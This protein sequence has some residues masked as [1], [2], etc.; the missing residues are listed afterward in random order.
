MNFLKKITDYPLRFLIPF[1]NLLG[2]FFSLF[3]FSIL[4]TKIIYKIYQNN[5][6]NQVGIYKNSLAKV[7]NKKQVFDKEKEIFEELSFLHSSF[8]TK[9]IFVINSLTN[10]ILYSTEIFYLYKDIKFLEFT[11]YNFI[12]D[13]FDP[14]HKHPYQTQLASLQED[15]FHI[16]N[17]YI[18]IFDYPQL[19]WKIVLIHEKNFIDFFL[20]QNI[21]L[22]LL[23]I[24]IHILFPFLFVNFIYNHYY[25]KRFQNILSF[26]EEIKNKNFNVRIPIEGKDEISYISSFL[27]NL[28][29]NIEK[30]IFYDSLTK[31]YNR[32]GFEFLGNQILKKVKSCVIF[33]MDLDGF[34]NVNESFGHDIG[35]IALKIISNRLNS[36]CENNPLGVKILLGR[37]GG[38]EFALLF[39][40]KL[41]YRNYLDIQI[42][43]TKIIEEVSQ[44]ITI[45]EIDINLGISIGIAIYPKDGKSLNE[46]LT[47]SDLAMYHSKNTTKN[48]YHFFSESIK[49]TYEQKNL[50]RNILVSIIKNKIIEKHFYLVYQPIYSLKENKITHIEALIR[51]RHDEIYAEPS[52]FI[53]LLEE[54]NFIEEIGNYVIEKSLNDYLEIK[55]FWDYK[56]SINL[57]LMQ[58]KSNQFFNSLKKTL[59]YLS[60]EPEKIIFEITESVFIKDPDSIIKAINSLVDF[61]ISF[62]LDDF[63]TGYSSL[64]YLKSFPIQYIKI[65]KSF[66]LNIINDEKSYIL[67]RSLFDLSKTINCKVIAEGV[68]DISTFNILKE[69]NCDY[70]QGYLISKPLEKKELITFLTKYSDKII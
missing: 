47:N 13:F 30:L 8:D 52:F 37:I 21:Y 19:N 35:D 18:Y 5:F 58:L 3:I 70:V 28:V 15:L 14:N 27:N 6:I 63:G 20:K 48:T 4:F 33:F 29:E 56:I 65:D 45:N 68:Q 7:I 32:F 17:H 1:F 34:K 57:S 60:I 41:D 38:D 59:T 22:I 44:K 49:K 66:L 12:L 46:L 31:V 43:A 50:L 51:F 54:L 25:K 40:T 39:S 11:S 69:L 24:F 10:Q 23:M 16:K 61:G 64:H 26:S 53:P 55:N 9:A 36:L 67:L 62:A 42:F 2:V